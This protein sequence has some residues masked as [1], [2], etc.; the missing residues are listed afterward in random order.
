MTDIENSIGDNWGDWDIRSQIKQHGHDSIISHDG[1]EYI[2]FNGRQ[3][4]ILN[5]EDL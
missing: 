1:S 2:V 5:V 4:R 3:I